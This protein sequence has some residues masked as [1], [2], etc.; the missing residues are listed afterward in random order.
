MMKLRQF[1]VKRVQCKHC[2]YFSKDL[3]GSGE[4][5]GRCDNNDA[6]QTGNTLGMRAYPP[7]PHIERI[8]KG[9]IPYD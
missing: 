3:I 6:W 1:K 4:G 9:F 8:C 2:M 5:I 7:Y